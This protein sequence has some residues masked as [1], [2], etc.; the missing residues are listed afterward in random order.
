MKVKAKDDPWNEKVHGA[1][2]EETIPVLAAPNSG[3]LIT[4]CRPS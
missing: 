2:V 3:V 1:V 4:G